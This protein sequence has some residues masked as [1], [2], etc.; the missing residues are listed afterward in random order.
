M[1]ELK[2]IEGYDLTKMKIIELKS[3]EDF[4]NFYRENYGKGCIY[5]VKLAGDCI[6]K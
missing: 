4:F 5:D 6:E 3:Y 2:F 1:I